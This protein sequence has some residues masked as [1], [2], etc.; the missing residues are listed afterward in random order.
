MTGR[1]KANTA[2]RYLRPIRFQIVEL[3]E[4][5]TTV[6]EFG[7]GNGDL[8]FKLSYKI[9][10]GIGLDKSESLISYARKV[11]EKNN[12]ENLDFRIVDLAKESLYEFKVD[13]SIASLI[14][15]ILNRENAIELL[16]KIISSSKTT[17]ICG[18]CEPKNLKQS[19]LIWLDQRFTSHYSN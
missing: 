7:C 1:I 19:I 3:I 13:Y 12:V 10:T 16:G 17:I 14:F 6:A 8:L 2:D 5:N 11:K 4:P 15:H 9:R 18:F